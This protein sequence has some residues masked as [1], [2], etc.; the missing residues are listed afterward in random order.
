M[1]SLKLQGPLCHLTYRDDLAKLLI[2]CTST[3]EIGDK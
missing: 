1:G 3:V 2:K